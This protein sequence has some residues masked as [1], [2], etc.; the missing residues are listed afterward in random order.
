MAEKL[1][2]H[3]DLSNLPVNHSSQMQISA[4]SLN[5]KENIPSLRLT[6][7]TSMYAKKARIKIDVNVTSLRY[8]RVDGDMLRDLHDCKSIHTTQLRSRRA[9]LSVK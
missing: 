2:F 4:H 9:F 8:S 1:L 5:L 3:S 7:S 6:V